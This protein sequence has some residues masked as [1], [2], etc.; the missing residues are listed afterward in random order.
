MCAGC[1][2][3][4]PIS[5]PRDH[6]NYNEAGSQSKNEQIL[7]NIIRLRYHQPIYFVE[8]G[9]MLSQYSLE[10]GADFMRWQNDLNVWPSAALRATYGVDGDPSEQAQWAANLQY[11]D[12]PTI[13]YTPLQGKE[14][15][16]RFLAPIP[17]ATI[18]YLSQSGWSIDQ[19]LEC[20]VQQ[21]NDLKNAPIHDIR[22]GDPWSTTKFHRAA[23]ILMKVQDAG[24]LDWGVQFDPEQQAT[25]LSV[26]GGKSDFEEEARELAELLDL[27]EELHQIRL[28]PSGVRTSRD[29]LVMKTRSVLGVM[30]ALAQT[31]EPPAEHLNN[32]QVRQYVAGPVDVPG[33]SWLRIE[34]GRVP[35]LD[36]FVQVRYNGYWWFIRKTDWQSKDTFALISYLFAL[37][38]SE[39]DFRAPVVTVQA[40][41]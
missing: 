18:I 41:G 28:N 14:F 32:G 37:Q 33:H 25:Y 21:L 34:H 11:A 20:C 15:A 5:V 6:F 35:V 12:R 2:S 13:T 8:I 19:L 40:G 38:A 3:L 39:S 23:E 24:A 36:A 22:E 16:T 1:K 9:S 17:T 29:E 4:G 31:V 27:P 26:P 7:L 30:K 10:A